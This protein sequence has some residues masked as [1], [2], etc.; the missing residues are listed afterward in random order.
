MKLKYTAGLLAIATCM[1]MAAQTPRNGYF[2]ENLPT[3]HDL[4]PA[5]APDFDYVTIPVL[6]GISVGANSNVGVG[7]F[8][9]KKNGEVVT[10]L[11][12]SVGNDEF[13]GKLKSK[14]YM[15]ANV[16]VNIL[17]A[18]FKA[19]GGFNSIGISLKSN[20]SVSLPKSLFE[21]AKVG[22]VDGGATTY[23]IDGTRVRTAE[24]LEFALGHSRDLNEKVRI[25]AKLKY[26]AGAAYADLTVDQLDVAMSAEQWSVR[27]QGHA[28]Y[29]KLLDV[30]Y[31]ANG[32]IDDIDKGDFGVA[33]N[34]LGVDLGVTYKPI[35][36]LTLS[37]A[38]TDLG[39][40]SWKGEK[41]S[42]NPDEFVY[43]GFHHLVAEKDENG[44]SQLKQEGDQLEEDAKKLVRFDTETS[45]SSLQSL[46]T[47]LNLAAQYNI[48]NDKIGFGLLSATRF[49]GSKVWEE[50]MASAN[51]RPAS[52]FNATVNFSA[53]NLGSSFGALINF[54]P[55]GFNFFI[56][57]D[58]IP[59]KYTS[60]G[61]PL[62]T[63]KFNF[64]LGMAITFN[65]HKK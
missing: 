33:G 11:H 14:N 27:E 8:L 52:W 53:S 51:F 25:G 35:K 19:W 46:M 3:R 61:I 50:V 15:E 6:G 10:G 58:Y 24:Y 28:F 20:T 38:L 57:T 32:E 43:D 12:S 22:Q 37:A 44:D 59:T 49:G 17:S 2:S 48:L 56:G 41:A 64:V 60:E 47:T 31:K 42:L 1:G 55:R 18:G 65:H 40:I 23:N 54:C 4:N 7:N 34:G 26:L 16:G 45:A 30:K 21:F 9:F 39:F 5:F 63:A 29:T 36:D 62:S 13:L